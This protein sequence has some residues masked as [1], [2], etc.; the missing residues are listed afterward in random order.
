VSVNGCAVI[1]CSAFKQA[2]RT[3]LIAGV[4]AI[5]LIWLKG[6]IDLIAQRGKVISSIR[7]RCAASSTDRGAS[8]CDVVDVA[9]KPAEIVTTIRARL[10]I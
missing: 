6:S 10:A 4:R 5:R 9:R 1:A 3:V 8:R 7:R 2:H